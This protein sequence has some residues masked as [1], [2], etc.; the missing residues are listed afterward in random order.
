M[1][2]GGMAVD[3]KDFQEKKML[4]IF[5]ELERGEKESVK[6][7]LEMCSRCR[8]EF[9]ELK[10]IAELLGEMPE[11]ALSGRC[12]GSIRAFARER[13][14]AGILEKLRQIFVPG[15]VFVRRRAF[16][17][18]MALAAAVFMGFCLLK[19]GRAPAAI[20]E[21]EDMLFEQKIAQ[22][23]E[24]AANI[25]YDMEYS[26]YGVD[27]FDGELDT[28]EEEVNRLLEETERV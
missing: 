15:G 25:S 23:E 19:F 24:D 5:N 4:Y 18:A 6:N 21:W 11:A 13:K 14:P 28:L 10:R 8:N 17:G 12:I 27:T 7:H 9:K 22:V 16:C 20:F 3:C 1:F 26:L 2:I